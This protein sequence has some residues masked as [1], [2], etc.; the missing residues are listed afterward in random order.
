MMLMICERGYSSNEIAM[1]IGVSLKTVR[2]YIHFIESMN[3]PVYIKDDD[4]MGMP[5][6]PGG[7]THYYH[8]DRHWMRRF[9]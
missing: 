1:R 7:R 5:A 9:M 6:K 3:V 4:E 2:R 8:I